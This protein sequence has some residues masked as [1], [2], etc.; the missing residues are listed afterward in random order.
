M[1]S[2]TR[3]WLV[4]CGIGCGFLIL[5]AG[6]IGT[7]SYVGIQKI[8]DRG[9]RLDAGFDALYAE[10]GRPADFV[11]PAD[12]VVP[13]GRLEAFLA[14]RETMAASRD[15]LADVLVELDAATEGV[16]G[17][18]KK[19][20]AGF[21]VLPRMFDFIEERNGALADEGMGVGEY[22]YIYSLAY[23]SWL[24]RSP[25]DGPSFTVS[26]D[27]DEDEDEDG[28][29]FRWKGSGHHD[30][31]EDVRARRE[32]QIRRYLN[33]I[34]GRMVA[35]QLDA[36]RARGL[37]A[38]WLAQLEAEH[39]ALDESSGRLVWEEGLPEAVAAALEPFRGRLE[40]SYSPIMNVVEVGLVENE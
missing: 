13:A 38:G 33:R 15:E 34:Q 35:N 29:T 19:I 2:G 31:P 16:G 17:V 39:A 24:D 28:V 8:K 18:I 22:L 40:A 14:V 21:S 27:D 6:G 25:A 20:N 9:E 4:G 37:D 11:P 7:C 5:A 10:Y 32:R 1:A 30:D 3:K 36:A 23:Y 12:G 26:D